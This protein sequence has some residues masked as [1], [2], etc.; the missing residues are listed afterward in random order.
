MLKFSASRGGRGGKKFYKDF[1]E[2]SEEMANMGHYLRKYAISSYLY[3]PGETETDPVEQCE[4]HRAWRSVIGEGNVLLF[5]FDSKTVPVTF[6][7]LFDK[8]RGVSSYI[9]PSKSWTEALEKYHVVV[10]L[11]EDVPT[12]REGFKALYRAAA[13]WLGLDGLYDATMESATQQMSPHNLEN[14]LEAHIE[15]SPLDVR[16]VLASYAPLESAKGDKTFG[17]FID[18]GAVFTLSKTGEPVSVPE[19]IA[20]VDKVGK[21]RVHCLNGLLHDGRRDTAFVNAADDGGYIYACSGGTCQHTLALRNNP[22]KPY[23]AETE[24]ETVKESLMNI[25]AEHPVIGRV[26]TDDKPEAGAYESA[27]QYGLSEIRRREGLAEVEGALRVFDGVYWRQVFKHRSELFHHIQDSIIEMGFVG[28]AYRNAAL[29]NAYNVYKNL[30]PVKELSEV[31]NYLNLKN[32]V[33]EIAGDGIREHAHA[34]EYLFTS[35]LPYEYDP[36]AKAPVW[37]MVVDRIMCGDRDTKE[38][39]QQALGYLLLRE[40]NLEKMVC[41]V[42]EGENGKSTIIRVLKKLVGRSGYA[43]QPIQTLLKPGSEGHYAKAQLAGKLINLTNELTPSSL[44]ADAFKDLISGE[45]I[46]ARNIYEA[47]FVLRTVPKQLVAMNTTESLI[48]ERTHGFMRRLHLIPFNYTLK[49]EHKDKYLDKK[50]DAELSGILNW[51]LEGARAVIA[52]GRLKESLAMRRLFENVK[53]DSNPVQQFM[54]EYLVVL[55][56]VGYDDDILSGPEIYEKY[57]HFAEEN[58]YLSV[59]RNKFLAELRRLGV[60][61]IDTTRESEGRPK[62]KL[63]GYLCTWLPEELSKAG[64]TQI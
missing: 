46:T 15:G 17:G 25:V 61:Q 21:Q 57:R 54:E 31:G 64:Y 19:M 48:K 58:R 50:L 9:A 1:F 55:S 47:P 32:C 34:S 5:D 22:F 56:D 63:K 4:G 12:T 7:M 62:R 11:S 60:R 59:G 35:V 30:V 3:G 43:A 37:E 18:E 40:F 29:N 13:Q 14:P 24:V 2:E 45:D 49:E 33:L 38:A 42:G 39:F 28:M 10:E 36:K 6:E 20:L 26:Y 41:F 27:I 8:F 53:R 16:R 52:S 23:A 44:T 51:V